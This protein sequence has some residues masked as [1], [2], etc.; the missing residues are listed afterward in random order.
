MPP[1]RLS[2]IPAPPVNPIEVDGVRYEQIRNGLT[3]GLDQ[4]GGYLAAIDIASGRQLWVLKVY[5]NR[6]DPAL[7]GDVQDV[8]FRS[9]TRQADGTLLIENERRLRFVVDPATRSVTPA[10]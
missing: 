8:F 3:A 4:M 5:D 9:M 6:R 2:R 1:P 10:P 7:E